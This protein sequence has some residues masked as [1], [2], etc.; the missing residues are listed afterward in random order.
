M[1]SPVTFCC[2]PSWGALPLQFVLQ[3]QHGNFFGLRLDL[4]GQVKTVPAFRKILHVDEVMMAFRLRAEPAFDG[5]GN[6]E[7]SLPV[8]GDDGLLG[9]LLLG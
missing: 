8:P 5:A 4:H 9:R 7:Q 6:V 3:F 2:E 1:N